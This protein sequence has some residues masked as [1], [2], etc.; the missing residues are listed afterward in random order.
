MGAIDRET[1]EEA[2]LSYFAELQ[3]IADQPRDIPA[4]YFDQELS[5]QIEMTRGEIDRLDHVLIS[6]QFGP[7]AEQSARTMLVAI[8]GDFDS[9]DVDAQR[10]A[11]D[12][13]V[14]AERQQMRYVLHSLREPGPRYWP[15]AG[16]MDTEIS[17]FRLPQLRVRSR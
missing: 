15:A 9:V 13:A 10:S 7:S 1:L 3:S 14:R 16:L 12:Y 17:S 5:F 8:G 11:M 6:K 2:A 4:D